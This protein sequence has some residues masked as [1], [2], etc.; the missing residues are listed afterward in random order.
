MDPAECEGIP[1]INT[2]DTFELRNS[3]G[4]KIGTARARGLEHDTASPAHFRLYI[5]DVTM[6]ASQ[7]F[8]GTQKIGKSGLFEAN[9]LSTALGKR[10]DAGQNSL[11]FKLPA[12]A[13]ST[14][15]N[16]ANHTAD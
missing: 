14:L 10:F 12:D 5:F 13:I 16:G 6:N 15:K 1:D 11:V 7:A 2:L 9:L 8:G 3:G 4:T